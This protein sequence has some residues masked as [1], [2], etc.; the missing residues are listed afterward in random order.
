LGVNLTARPPGATSCLW[1][2]LILV[3]NPCLQYYQALFFSLFSAEAF[4]LDYQTQQYN[5]F[6]ILATAFAFRFTGVHVINMFFK[7]QDDINLGNLD[8]LP[9][10]ILL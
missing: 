8:S 2:L 10:V 9:E 6:P 7:I 1:K 4:I 3:G 5:L